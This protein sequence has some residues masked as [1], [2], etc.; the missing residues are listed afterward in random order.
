Y[1]KGVVCY[2]AGK[3]AEAEQMFRAS[4]RQEVAASAGYN[5]GNSLVQQQKLK[6]AI[7]AY[8]AV[9]E[10]W[11][12]HTKAKENLELVKKM[13]EEK[14]DASDPENSDPQTEGDRSSE[15]EEK[16]ESQ[17]SDD[18]E[19]NRDEEPQNQVDPQQADP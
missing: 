5:L 1:R 15:N 6:E 3:F 2:K 11:P 14:P 10:K 18:R 7:A 17:G 12:D 8:E 13:V 16:S 9:L 19:Q 4:T